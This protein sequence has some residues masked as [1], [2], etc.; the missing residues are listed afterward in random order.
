MAQPLHPW[1]RYQL[2]S[3]AGSNA[4]SAW[5]NQP[6]PSWSWCVPHGC[7]SWPQPGQS[8]TQ[9]LVLAGKERVKE[10]FRGEKLPRCPGD[11][12]LPARCL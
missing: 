11:A 4:G 2:P 8:S 1:Q 7:A 3:R 5:K 9:H 6:M 12:E 10:K